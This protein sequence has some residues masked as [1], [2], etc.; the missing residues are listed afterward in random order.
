MYDGGKLKLISGSFDRTVRIW[1]TTTWNCERALRYEGSVISLEACRSLLLVGL[2][3]Q[4]DE[5]V[6]VETGTIVVRNWESGETVRTLRCNG[7]WVYSLVVSGG[8]LFS[9]SYNNTIKVWT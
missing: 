3:E 4:D 9:C 7:G 1:D 5:E 2:G 8:K 6:D